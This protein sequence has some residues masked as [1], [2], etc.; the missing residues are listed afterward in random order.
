MTSSSDG[1]RL[2]RLMTIP[3]YVSFVTFFLFL[4]SAAP[5]WLFSQERLVLRAT[6][7]TVDVDELASGQA[8]DV[9]A[10]PGHTAEWSFMLGM[11]LGGDWGGK[12][13]SLTVRDAT[14][15]TIESVVVGSP[16]SLTGTIVVPENDKTKGAYVRTPLELPEDT[17]PG[18]Y[19]GAFVGA[20]RL[21][22]EEKGL[23][24][25]YV[26]YPKDINV[27]LNVMVVTAEEAAL[28][29]RSEARSKAALLGGATLVLYGSMWWMDRAQKRRRSR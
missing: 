24:G 10:V 4:Y 27:A 14:G 20:V 12:D 13:L 3:A 23:E 28:R 15:S 6:R 19:T 29:A 16:N 26:N 22:Q 2:G 18:A 17:V 8:V 25:A 1:S 11:S 9:Y 7:L 21:P 5:A